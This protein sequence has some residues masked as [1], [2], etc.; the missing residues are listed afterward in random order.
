MNKKGIAALLKKRILILDG[1]TGT[2]LQKRGMPGGVCPEAWCAQRPH[3]LREV[4]RAYR[5]AGADVIYTC[6]FGANGPKLGEYGIDDVRGVNERMAL[7]AREAA[8]PGGLVA[9]DIGPTGRFVEPFGEL[10]FEAAVTVFKEQVAGLLAG[11]VDLFVIETMMDIQEARAALLAVKESSDLFT[12]VT[13]TYEA[14]GRTL[15][16]TDPVTALITLQSLGADAVGCNCSVGPAE[17]RDWIAAMKPYATVPLAAKPNAGLPRLAGGRTH[18]DMGA[19]EFGSWGEAFHRAGVNLLGGC[20]GTTP[21]HIAAIRAATASSSPEPPR[22]RS[23]AAVSSARTHRLLERNRPLFIIGERLNPTGKKQ[24]QQ[25]LREG[26]MSLVRRLAREQEWQGAD[27]LDVNVGVPGIDE[28]PTMRETIRAVTAAS[29][30]P[31]VID[32]PKVATIEAALRLYPGR[33][34]INSI[35]GELEKV[36]K[37]LPLAAKYGAM[38]ILLPLTDGEIPATAAGRAAVV[39]EVF[40]AA[41]RHGFTKE[42]IVVDGLVMTVAANQ[43]APAETLKTVSWASRTFGC[44]TVLGV[45]NV[46]FGLPERKWLNAAMLGLAQG[47]GLSMAIVNP[48][49]P[50]LQ[51]VMK[52]AD[53]LLGRDRQAARYIAAFSGAGPEGK[54]PEQEPSKEPSPEE[55][56]YQAILE[57]N[58]EDIVAVIEAALDGVAAGELVDKRMIPAIMRVGEL[59][60]R[61]TYFLPQ[62]MASA[63]AMKRGLARLAPLLAASATNAAGKGRIVLATVRGDIHDIGK[64]IVALMLRNHGYEV[65]DLGKD[66]TTAAILTAIKE[67]RP[68]AAG[69]SALMTTTMTAMGDVIAA[70]RREGLAVPFILGGAVVTAAY[71]ESLGAAYA[72]DSVEAVRV[73]G[74]LLEN[75]T[76]TTAPDKKGDENS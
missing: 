74:G 59:Y 9:G 67:H 75:E 60:E 51:A 76:F 24:L 6:T 73:I 46:S 31:L 43:E 68:R 69:L 44:R 63:E 25:E 13:M 55:R 50:E 18:F 14:G 49:G 35:S 4:Q 47:A 36:E 65:I 45:S 62:L 40:L 3:L 53:V 15:N 7:L 39:R 20:C 22:R 33:A 37:L 23:L 16:G 34:L 71:A 21:E 58:R 29:S 48:A 11:G 5:E 27:L 70:A 64:N 72:R 54:P 32:S 57:G 17:M 10:P 12:I 56:V 26:K 2:E 30:L 52:A 66:V 42:D 1:A 8:G 61:Q 19:E 38:F 28:P 41:R